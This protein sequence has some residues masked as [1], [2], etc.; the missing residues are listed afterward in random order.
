MF[1]LSSRLSLKE[2]GIKE[3]SVAQQKKGQAAES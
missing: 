2:K 3:C 1:W